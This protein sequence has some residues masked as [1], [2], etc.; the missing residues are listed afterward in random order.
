MLLEVRSISSS[1]ND[2]VESGLEKQ[3]RQER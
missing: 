3:D 2:F 1:I